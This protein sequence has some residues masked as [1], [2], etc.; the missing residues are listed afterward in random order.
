MKSLLTLVV[1]VS[2]L[3][4]GIPSS[5]DAGL[6]S[7]LRCCRVKRCCK[8]QRRCCTPAPAPCCKPAPAPCCAAPATGCCDSTPTCSEPAPVIDQ[9]VSDCGGC[10]GVIEGVMDSGVGEAIQG[11]V[12]EGE[13][14]EGE[15]IEGEIISSPS[16][17]DTGEVVDP[18]VDVAP[19]IDEATQA[20]GI[21]YPTNSDCCGGEVVIQQV[22]S[23]GG[24][25]HGGSS[26]VVEG[27]V[28]SG[29]S[30]IQGEVIYDSSSEGGIVDGVVVEGS[31]TVVVESP[32]AAS[33]LD[34][35]PAEAPAADAVPEAPAEESAADEDKSA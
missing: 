12:I 14:I 17:V 18:P 1:G 5:A 7:R 6:F 9:P 28:I 20:T 8:P 30:I 21:S 3:V 35:A 25:V 33:G 23:D 31:E 27:D 22:V 15:I 24:I 34:A 10:G 11:S 2:L 19:A 16:D 29:E 26:I 4:G 13:I 32:E